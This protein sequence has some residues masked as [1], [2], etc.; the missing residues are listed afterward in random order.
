M[1]KLVAAPGTELICGA[2][3]PEAV[4][5]ARTELVVALR[6]EME[7]ALHMGRASRTPGNQGRAKQK[8]ENGADAARHHEAD[9]HPEP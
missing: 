5:A 6:A 8:V 3:R 9:Q 1:R 4:S 2:N 7:I